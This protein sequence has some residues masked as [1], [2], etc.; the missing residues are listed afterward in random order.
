MIE[1][2]A[3]QSD[4]E[5]IV[6]LTELKTLDEPN[7]LFR[8]VHV[9]TGE[10]VSFVKLS[11]DDFSDYPS[12]FNKFIVDTLTV[13]SGKPPG[14]WHYTVYEQASVVNTDPDLATGAVEYGK[15]YLLPAAEYATDMYDN[16]PRTF[17][18]YQG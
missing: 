15:M 12:R 9:G 17:K 16:S 18:M 7:W 4:Q 3:G 14:E 13:F 5:V 8:F 11:A 2:T 6:T 10:V 1:L